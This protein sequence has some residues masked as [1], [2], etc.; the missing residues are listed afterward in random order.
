M[1]KVLR[2]SRFYPKTKVCAFLFFAN[3]NHIL[4]REVAVYALY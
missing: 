4:T 1:Q 3:S 2:L